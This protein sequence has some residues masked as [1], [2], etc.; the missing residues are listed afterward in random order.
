MPQSIFVR[1][2]TS[3]KYSSDIFTINKMFWQIFVFFTVFTTEIHSCTVTP[4]EMRYSA[5]P[6]Y[7]A[8]QGNISKYSH[9]VAYYAWANIEFFS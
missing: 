4:W 1:L 2:N 8:Q 6:S 7:V 3:I 9:N 5:C